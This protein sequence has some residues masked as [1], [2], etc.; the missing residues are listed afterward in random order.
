MCQAPRHIPNR[1]DSGRSVPQSSSYDTTNFLPVAAADESGQTGLFV[2]RSWH[3]LWWRYLCGTDCWLSMTL[4]SYYCSKVRAFR[5]YGHNALMH[6][7]S[8]TT[9]DWSAVG[10]E[11]C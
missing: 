1:F 10:E 5:S 11:R 8:L 9:L 7:F 2:H 3:K 6:A 4:G